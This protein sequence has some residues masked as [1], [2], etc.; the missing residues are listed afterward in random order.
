MWRF[1]SVLFMQVGEGDGCH[2]CFALEIVNHLSYSVTQ[3]M[4]YDLHFIEMNT[5]IR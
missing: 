3:K 5:Y 4:E 2:A 1:Y